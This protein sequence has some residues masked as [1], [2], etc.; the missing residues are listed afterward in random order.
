M[1][2]SNALPCDW[3]PLNAPWRPETD[4]RALALIG[5]KEETYSELEATKGFFLDVEPGKDA[6]WMCAEWVWWIANM[7]GLD[8]GQELTPSAIVEAAQ[9][10]GGP[11][12]SLEAP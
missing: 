7:D 1:P 11:L 10:L 3:L 6:R 4:R 12:F 5:R 2:L 8:L 9:R